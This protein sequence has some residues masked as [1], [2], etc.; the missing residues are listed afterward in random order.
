MAVAVAGSATAATLLSEPFDTA[1]SSANFGAAQVQPTSVDST[2]TF[3][4]DYSTLTLPP[5]APGG[6]ANTPVPE[7]PNTAALGG[8]AKRGLLLAV[9]DGS[10][11]LAQS[12]SVF[13]GLT[14]SGDYEAQVDVFYLNIGATGSTE[15]ILYGINHSGTLPLAFRNNNATGVTNDGYFFKTFGDVDV[16]GPDYWLSKGAAI[17]ISASSQPGTV[18]ADG[19]NPDVPARQADD[20]LFSSPPVNGYAPSAVTPGSAFRW[21]WHTV[22]LSYVQGI[23]TLSING[24]PIATY[25]DPADTFT[26]GKV[27]L[28]AED[29]FTGINAANRVIFDN[30]LVK[31]IS[32]SESWTM[33]Q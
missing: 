3:G 31:S 20:A 11:P 24:T 9:N 21:A 2:A 17:P 32:A 28:G 14:F 33:Y 26:S 10:T 6:L 27:A 29:T 7:A 25:D 15:D 19:T 8:V 23:V 16:A 12:I 22:K 1:G 4:G 18:W 30:L 13:T 5:E